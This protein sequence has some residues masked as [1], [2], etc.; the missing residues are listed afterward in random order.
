VQL[1][2]SLWYWALD[3]GGLGILDYRANFQELVKVMSAMSVW[4]M[5]WYLYLLHFIAIFGIY[6]RLPM[7]GEPYQRE[8]WKESKRLGIQARYTATMAVC[9]TQSCWSY[10]TFPGKGGVVVNHTQTGFYLLG[11]PQYDIVFIHIQ[12]CMLISSCVFPVRRTSCETNLTK[13][14]IYICMYTYI[15]TYIYIHIFSIPKDRW[16]SWERRA[17]NL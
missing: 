15:Y 9:S 8:T 1:W 2:P 12:D 6:L 16:K 13:D 3:H 4:V 5:F 10:P 14:I 7:K 11:L 17:S